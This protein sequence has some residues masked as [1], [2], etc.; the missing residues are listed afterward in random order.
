LDPICSVD[1]EVLDILSLDILGLVWLLFKEL[2]KTHRTNKEENSEGC[3]STDQA[4]GLLPIGHQF[5]SH[6][7]QGYWRLPWSLT[8]GPV[9]LVEVR[10]N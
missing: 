9:G 10:A 8:S 3:S 6:R 2:G 1:V 4:L 5:E 7:P